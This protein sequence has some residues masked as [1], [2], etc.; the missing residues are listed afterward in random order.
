MPELQSALV[1]HDV[2][3]IAQQA[4][5]IAWK[6]FHDGVEIHPLYDVDGGCSAA[7]LRYAPGASIP[8]HQHMG[9][10]HIL[11]LVGE[12]QDESNV[13]SQGSLVVSPP[14]SSHAV[15][16]PQGCIVLAIWEKPVSFL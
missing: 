7:L 16:S 2:L 9:Y 13:Y 4:D 6:P 3:D 1:F 11:V 5:Q 15:Q 8:S 12:Q 14:G 10:E